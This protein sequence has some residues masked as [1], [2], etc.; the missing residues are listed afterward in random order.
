MKTIRRRVIVETERLLLSGEE[1]GE[2]SWCQACRREVTMFTVEVAVLGSGLRAVEIYRL[3]QMGLIHFTETDRGLL[4]ICSD[5]LKV[6]AAMTREADA[7][8]NAFWA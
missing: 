2:Q 6:R 8:A 3:V 4:R 1:S 7:G 5:S